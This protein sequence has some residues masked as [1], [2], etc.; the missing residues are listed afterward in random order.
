MHESPLT[1]A[2]ALFQ[3]GRLSIGL[4]LPWVE[5]AEYKGER[6]VDFRRQL[7]LAAQAEA[8]GFAALWVRDVPLNHPGYPESI[9]HLDPWVWLGA[10]AA[11]TH[12]IALVTGAI[13]LTLRHPLHVA[14]GATSVAALAPGRFMLGLG[15]GDRPPE[16]LAFGRDAARRRE[17]F[18]ARWEQLAAALELPARVLPDRL[19]DPPIDFSLRP[20]A[21]MPIPML[22]VGSAGQSL[23]WIARHAIGWMTYHRE[24]EVQQGRHR[25]WRQ[26]VER[27]APGRFRGFGVAMRV[28]LLDRS[29]APAEPIELGYRTGLRALGD[30]LSRMREAGTHHVS[31][32]LSAGRR[33]WAELIEELGSLGEFTP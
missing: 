20:R 2:T 19:D 15:S 28:E 22:A 17:D 4:G 8:A 16:Y 14:K 1:P 7:E 18:R 26:A 27:A 23:D 30:I 24:P 33:P 29:D 25:F 10:L 13:V 12:R 6:E 31:L 21:A 5:A 9:G 11:H 3:P 32:N